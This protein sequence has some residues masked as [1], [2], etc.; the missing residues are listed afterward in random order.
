MAFT[1][2]WCYQQSQKAK[3]I[4]IA[5]IASVLFLNISTVGY[6]KKS[7]F[8]CFLDYSLSRFSAQ[9]ERT[10]VD[11]SLF[12][13]S[14]FEFWSLPAYKNTNTR[15]SQ[16]TPKIM[17]KLH[18]AWNQKRHCLI[19]GDTSKV[20]NWK[21]K[22]DDEMATTPTGMVEAH[23]EYKCNLSSTRCSLL[24]RPSVYLLCSMEDIFQVSD[25]CHSCYYA[26]FCFLSS[27]MLYLLKNFLISFSQEI[28]CLWLQSKFCEGSKTRTRQSSLKEAALIYGYHGHDY[29]R[30]RSGEWAVR[31]VGGRGANFFCLLV[32]SNL[33]AS[34]TRI[35]LNERLHLSL[36]STR[37][38]QKS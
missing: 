19:K 25:S 6:W 34:S 36:C 33:R 17:K 1:F 10:I 21:W 37:S 8:C 31:V 38:L 15:P 11:F 3:N 7:C 28:G 30:A 29:G 16:C 5:R 23:L 9:C 32:L 24:F 18:S 20:A 14:N 12:N 35:F 4:H 26:W 2:L 22:V 27:F 13:S